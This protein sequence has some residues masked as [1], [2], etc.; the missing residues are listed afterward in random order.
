MKY[1]LLLLPLF[2]WSCKS[3][4]IPKPMVELMDPPIPILPVS[5]INVPIEID[6]QSQLKEVEKSLPK[7]FEGK[8]EQCEGI[9]FAYKFIREPINFQLKKTS[10]YYEVDG[11]FELKLNYCPKCHSLWDD[12]GSCTVPRI[13]ASCGVGEPMRRVKV[14]YNTSVSISDS[15][16]FNTETKLK[17]FD[18][19]DPCEITVFKYDATSQVEKQVKSQLQSLEKEIDKQIEAVDIRSSIKDVWRQLEEPIDLSGYGFLYLKPKNMALS[20]VTFDAVNKRAELTAELKAEPFITTNYESTV[21]SNLPKQTKYTTGQGFALNI[22]V[23]ASYDSINK[24]MNKD[25]MGYKIPFNGKEIVVDSLHIIGNQEQK[26]VIQVYFSG[27]KKGVF[28]L[29]GTPIITEDQF[30]VLTNLAYDLN[31]KSVLLKTAKWM[32]DKRILE[33]LN[34]SAKYDLNPLLSETKNSITQQLNT[35][36]DEGVFLSGSA[37]RLTVSNIRLGVSGFFLTTEVSGNLKLKMK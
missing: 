18:V 25:L 5:Q 10:F 27:S 29:V 36:L 31:S 24:L 22:L 20:S 19:L 16:T 1:F 13:Y 21:Y 34:K 23:K 8:Q 12:N 32:F 14:G 30:F 35:K 33:E 11:K 26:I 37:D 6:L 4:D 2:I 3:I 28:F 9:S 15:Y 17:L 7:I